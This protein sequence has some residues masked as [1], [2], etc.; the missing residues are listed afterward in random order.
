MKRN[1]YLIGFM[2]TGKSTV[3]GSLA[4]L[5]GYEEIDTD[6]CISIQQNKSIAEIFESQGETAFRDLE[7]ALLKKLAEEEQ[8]IISCGG[9]MALREEN[10]AF[11]RQSGIVVLLTAE[12]ETIFERVS[13]DQGRPVLNGNMNV[14]YIRRLLAQR[15]PYY[16]AAKELEAVTDGRSP[17]EIAEEIVKEM[18]KF[19]M[20]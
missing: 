15:A 5:L 18:K 6:A 12:P 20:I 17:Q 14:E 8:K 3:S 16:Q 13:R 9:G 7:T 2:G 10:A 19:K 4:R 11:M 1:I